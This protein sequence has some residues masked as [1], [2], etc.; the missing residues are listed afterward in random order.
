MSLVSLNRQRGTGKKNI[1]K[2]ANFLN[3]F[4]LSNDKN[5]DFIVLN[6]K[7]STVKEIIEKISQLKWAHFNLPDETDL[8][9]ALDVTID[10]QAE[11]QELEVSVPME[12]IDSTLGREKVLQPSSEELTFEPIPCSVALAS[13][14]GWKTLDKTLRSFWETENLSEEQPIISDEL[15]YCEKHFERTHFRKPCGRYSVSLPF[16]ENIQENVNLGDSR[17]IASKRLD[18]IWRRL[19]R[20]PKLNNLYTKLIEE[21]LSLDHMEE[22]KNIDDIASEEGFFLPHHSVFRAGNRSRPL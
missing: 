12:K 4:Q 20:D 16:K 13:K 14:R 8:K 2:C 1:A 18:H 15:S 7:L 9:D 10:L 6:N 3:T 22:I 11:T 5:A 21:Y 19:D 17:P